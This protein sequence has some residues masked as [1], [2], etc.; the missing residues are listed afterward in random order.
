MR[1]KVG[2]RSEGDSV[3]GRRGSGLG[4][5]PTR[6]AEARASNAIAE[7]HLAA[8]FDAV[9]QCGEAGETGE[10]H[11]AEEDRLVLAQAL[12]TPPRRTRGAWGAGIAGQGGGEAPGSGVWREAS[13]QGVEV[14]WLHAARAV[15]LCRR[16][17]LAILWRGRGVGR[18]RRLAG[19][20]VAVGSVSPAS[21]AHLL[22]GDP[23]LLGIGSDL[24]PGAGGARDE[25]E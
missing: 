2:A 1:W 21:P 6:R 13:H 19:R 12:R 7:A 24:Q 8:R 4:R 5:P 23:R 3:A 14:R 11:A 16:L 9:E 18:A 25:R 17:P 22:N 15:K 10:A 20:W